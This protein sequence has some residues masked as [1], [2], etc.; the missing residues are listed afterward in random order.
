MSR[1]KIENKIIN[2]LNIDKKKDW[3]WRV[4]RFLEVYSLSANSLNYIK[5][6][7]AGISAT[8]GNIY[9]LPR[10]K[11]GKYWYLKNPKAQRNKEAILSFK[12]YSVENDIELTVA[13][14]PTKDEADDTNWYEEM[15]EFLRQNKITYV[16]L[17]LIFREKGISSKDLYWARD[18]HLNPFGNKIVAEI[19]INEF[20]HIFQSR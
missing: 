1:K 12:E 17:T 20:P 2:S 9:S 4:K 7:V 13:L 5:K 16:D 14:I 15:R 11:N 3:L 19:L 8:H 10:E 6:Y 18:L